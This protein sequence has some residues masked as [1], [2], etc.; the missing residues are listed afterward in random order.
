MSKDLCLPKQN[1]F[2]IRNV[3]LKFTFIALSIR[4]KVNSTS[5]LSAFFYLSSILLLIRIANFALSGEISR[6]DVSFILNILIKKIDF[7][8]SVLDSFTKVA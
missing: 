4:I 2:P 1:S 5:L 6:L 7:G 3:I 8:F